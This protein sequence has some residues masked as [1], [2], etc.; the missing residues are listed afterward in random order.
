[1]ITRDRRILSALLW[2]LIVPISAL[3]AVAQTP[4]PKERRETQYGI[5]FLG[6]R[7]GGST[8][9]E[10][11][12]SFRGKKA[13]KVD[14]ASKVRIAALGE[15]EQKVD[16]VQYVDEKWMPIH[17]RF[18]MSS[19]GHTA[20][21][22][23][24]FF[25]DRVECE[26]D[27]QGTRSKKTIPVPKGVSL[28]ADP[29]L[30][31]DRKLKV[32]EKRQFHLFEPLT[33]QILPL[34]VQVLRE[35]KLTLGGKTYQAS[36]LKTVNS[37]TGEGT[38][39]LTEDGRLL[40]GDSALGIRIV[41]EE[42]PGGTTDQKPPE[43]AYT[44]PVDL[45]V[46]TAIKTEKK[47]EEPRQTR[48]LRVRIAGIPERRLILSDARQQVQLEK[49]GAAPGASVTAIYELHAEP[50]GA[51]PKTG[52][53]P[54]GR[55][56]EDRAR[57]LKA[58]PYLEVTDPRIR[59][60]ARQVVGK[61]TDPGR[62]AEKIRAWIHGRMKADPTIGVPRS[63]TDVLKTPRGVCRDYAVLFAAVARAAGVPTRICSG[64]VYFKGSFFYHAWNECLVDPARGQWRAFDAT[65]PTDFVDATHIKFAQGD[66]TE[67]FHAVRVVG[68]LKAE[69][70][71]YR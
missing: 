10:T 46:A 15:V 65:L 24:D 41:R 42:G 39:W 50:G 22:V 66:P 48:Y 36:V 63:A 70:L 4:L 54:G 58:V 68:Q 25:P 23:A 18:S 32:G 11:P 37:M 9:V 13:L 60:Q 55:V 27:S 26:L 28:V 43:V 61:E 45:A 12:E 20:R 3:A 16:L 7:I 14:S 44:P 21:V 31:G 35:E 56:P 40:Q 19:A 2:A 49:N 64:I 52:D 34:D 59:E 17:L 8:V 67:M 62:K 33:L 71:E 5:F 38:Q 6:N 29:D 47:I 57:Y 51:A 69:I 30:L 53:K 1:M